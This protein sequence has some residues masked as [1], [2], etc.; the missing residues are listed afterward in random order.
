MRWR[1]IGVAMWLAR[2]SFA[3]AQ[4]P[5]LW[6]LQLMHSI[7]PAEGTPGMLGKVSAL[8][9]AEDGLVYVAEED[10]PRVTL[11][12]RTGTLA[13]VV[14]KNGDGPGETRY[15]EITMQAD[16]LVVYDPRQGRLSRIAPSGRLLSE[17][18]LDVNPGPGIFAPDDGHI[19][20]IAGRNS[21][22]WDDN[23]VR[24]ASNGTVDTLHWMHPESEDLAFIWH[25]PVWVLVGHMPFSPHGVAAVDPAGRVVIGGTRRS[26][27]VVQR[28]RDTVQ[29]VTLPDHDAPIAKPVR[30][31]VWMAFYAQVA[32][33]K[34]S[35]LDEF[36]REDRIPTT[37]PPW[38]SFDI[39]RRGEW[40]IG[41]PAGN[42]TLASWDVVSNGLLAGHVPIPA[43]VARSPGSGSM[44]SFGKDVVAMLHAE[45]DGV[46]WIGV[47]RIV[48]NTH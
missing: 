35:R 4:T 33:R 48:R 17:R 41:R 42:G 28:G 46:P 1:A 22:G 43:K 10:P 2:P 15:P 30:D 16:T 18:R 20:L 38:V 34:L 21:S 32:A 36:V 24:V 11:Y 5:P 23:A 25:G 44:L 12:D 7:R 14:M 37:L 19:L 29:T 26:R 9:V 31:S 8:A 27:W 40:W 13:R 6:H 45:E 39:D 47:Y 3:A